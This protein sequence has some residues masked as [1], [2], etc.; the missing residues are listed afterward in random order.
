MIGVILLALASLSAGVATFGLSYAAI[1]YVVDS[2]RIRS[3][4]RRIWIRLQ[5][6]I[7]RE[8]SERFRSY[9]GM[10]RKK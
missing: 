6:Q 1:C 2:L 8:Q 9:Q 4:R 10:W 5:A 3:A 7:A